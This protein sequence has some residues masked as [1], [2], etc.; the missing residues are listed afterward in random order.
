MGAC[1]ECKGLGIKYKIDEDLIIPDKNLSINEGA[2]SAINVDDEN[3]ITY[4]N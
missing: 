1:P 4:T 2:I 3:N